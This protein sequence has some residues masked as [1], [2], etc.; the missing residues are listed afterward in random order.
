MFTTR[1]AFFSTGPAASDLS[2]AGGGVF[3]AVSEAAAAEPAVVFAVSTA[4]ALPSGLSWSGTMVLA[5]LG[6]RV[7]AEGNGQTVEKIWRKQCP[8]ML[9]Q[10]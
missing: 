1:G 4:P 9:S 2:N 7:V 3:A 8:V 6:L 5:N 10:L